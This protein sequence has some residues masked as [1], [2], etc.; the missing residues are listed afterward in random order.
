MENSAYQPLVDEDLLFENVLALLEEPES[1][2]IKKE[3][4]VDGS[5]RLTIFCGQRDRGRVI[6]KN[7]C[8]IS[9]LRQLFQSIA[10]FEKRRIEVEVDDPRNPPRRPRSSS[11]V[12]ETSV[13]I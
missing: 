13:R 5:V 2:K 10:Y 4:R 11:P 1:L 6:G 8:T 7:G 12:R 9:A 3:I